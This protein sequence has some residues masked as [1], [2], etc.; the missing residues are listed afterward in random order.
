MADPIYNDG[1]V[2]FGSKILGGRIAENISLTGPSKIIERPN[3]IGGPNGWVAVGGFPH[4]TL[5][6]QVASEDDIPTNG[7][8]FEI[9]FASEDLNGTWVVVEVTRPFAI[10]DYWKCNATIRKAGTVES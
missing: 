3:E 6:F 5:T 2:L 4:G 10:A 9:D 7:D 1:A 8:T